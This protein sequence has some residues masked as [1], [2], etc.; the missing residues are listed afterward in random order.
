VGGAALANPPAA[1][2]PVKQVMLSVEGAWCSVRSAS[3][4]RWTPALGPAARFILKSGAEFVA[5]GRTDEGFW[6]AQLTPSDACGAECDALDLV[7]T[8]FDDGTSKRYPIS[9]YA[10]REQAPAITA[11]DYEASAAAREAWLERRKLSRLWSYAHTVWP[12]AELRHDYAVVT[13]V[14]GTLVPGEPMFETPPYRGWL[15]GIVQEGHTRLRFTMDKTQFM[16]WC[17]SSWRAFPVA[18]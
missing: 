2:P 4:T 8:R 6:S 3:V 13:P 11:G 12:V 18:F 15:V 9:S 16:C 14:P 5:L 10:D 7:F 17:N 1:P